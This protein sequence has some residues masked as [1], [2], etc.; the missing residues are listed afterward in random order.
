MT[1]TPVYYSSTTTSKPPTASAIRLKTKKP[2]FAQFKHNYYRKPVKHVTSVPRK[3]IITKVTSTPA[4][5]GSSTKIP[6]LSHHFGNFDHF[7]IQKIRQPGAVNEFIDLTLKGQKPAKELAFGYFEMTQH[8][9]STPEPYYEPSTTAKPY[10]PVF[11]TKYPKLYHKA[12]AGNYNPYGYHVPNT[13]PEPFKTYNI[14]TH[15]PY[16]NP[17]PEEYF[18]PA[19]E[20]HK[21]PYVSSPAPYVSTTTHDPYFQPGF[22]FENHL[23]K[24][25]TI[26]PAYQ[27]EY[28][29]APVDPYVPK[30]HHL[31]HKHKYV[32]HKHLKYPYGHENH[33]DGSDFFTQPGDKIQ[34]HILHFNDPW[35]P[36]G[37]K[38]K[39]TPSPPKY[40][41]Y[42]EYDLSSYY[43]Y[44]GSD[45]SSNQYSH[46]DD[47]SFYKHEHS[48]RKIPI[49][50]GREKGLKTV[51]DAFEHL[52]YLDD[53][54][55][56]YQPSPEKPRFPDIFDIPTS[57]YGTNFENGYKGYKAKVP[58][59]TTV[60]PT[61]YH[62]STIRP[63][64]QDL[65]KPFSSVTTPT[66]GT[67]TTQKPFK[68]KFK[69][70]GTVISTKRPILLSQPTKTPKPSILST[71]MPKIPILDHISN[72]YTQFIDEQSGKLT[73]F[74]SGLFGGQ[75]DRLSH[76]NAAGKSSSSFK[77]DRSSS[78]SI[79]LS[80]GGLNE[81]SQLEQIKLLLKEN[82]D[83]PLL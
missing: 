4:P 24:P 83:K 76:N 72:G 2:S 16:Y 23:H 31:G 40:Q 34:K 45:G 19:P 14:P 29:Y 21:I 10:I 56:Y 47:L 43:N 20:P 70:K 49:D 28:L 59:T 65:V 52:D 69:P 77:M 82:R 6:N 74:V 38:V 55:P 39:V 54:E 71:L 57:D 80:T 3:P 48:K 25:A 75:N 58:S 17:Q 13:T 22:E 26:Q 81:L 78:S 46:N 50:L 63:T 30:H 5:P 1:P 53:Y 9:V 18:Y 35:L 41:P 15:Q 36:K 51:Q 32:T 66:I 11:T 27:D 7:E 42:K 73:N 8:E 64:L 12:N 68:L 79:P 37:P 61:I 62:H 33:H 44:D 67:T 60:K